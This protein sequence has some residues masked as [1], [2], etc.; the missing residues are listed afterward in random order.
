MKIEIKTIEE[1][2]VVAQA[3]Y[4]Y[5]SYAQGVSKQERAIADSIFDRIRKF[6]D[7]SGYGE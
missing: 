5:S 7:E 6:L 2:E 3:L 4:E 1:L